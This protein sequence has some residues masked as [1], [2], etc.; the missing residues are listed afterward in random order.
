MAETRPPDTW[1]GDADHPP[2]PIEG[3]PTST[4]AMLGETERGAL[5]PRLV[6]SM[7]DFERW[8]GRQVRADR[9]VPSSVRGFFDNGGGRLYVARLVAASSTTASKTL[10]AFT[11]RAV[12]PGAWGTRVW[13][14]IR[15]A[16]TASPT[17]TDRFRMTLAYWDS[18]PDGFEP[19]DPFDPAQHGRTPRP[20]WLEDHDDLSVDPAS[21]DFFGTRLV[22]GKT[23]HPVSS[24]AILTCPMGATSPPPHSPVQGEFLDQGGEDGTSALEAADYIGLPSATRLEP[25]GLHALEN[26]EYRDVALVYAPYPLQESD[27]VARALIAHCESARFRFAVIDGPRD[28]EPWALEPRTALGASAYAACY[29]P[30]IHVPAPLDGALTVVPPGGHVLGVFARV[31]AERGVFKAPA[32]ERIRGAAGLRFTIDDRVQDDLGR[33]GVNAIRAFE[34][35]G[36]LVWGARTLSSDR[37]WT[38]VS[39]R[40]LLIYLERSIA[41]G[42]RWVVFEPNNERLWARVRD[43][44]R[45]F[46]R[47]QWRTGALAGHREQ[48]AF[49]V[50]C[51]RTTMSQDDILNGRLIAEIGVATMRP[52]EFVLFRLFQWTSEAA[53]P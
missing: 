50:N 8:F 7:A 18:R 34:G 31:D 15:A 20:Q 14:R 5:R 22:D 36:I 17:A 12:G 33:R 52:A 26:H 40:R 19:Y 4:A 46:L 35:R 38:Y 24:L 23:G 53:P 13:V 49:F 37:E 44:I 25:Q 10:G 11:L 30:W 1:P 47:A 43:S 39:T 9:F 51:D 42:T 45:L 28:V 16:S 3:V 27:A 29:A 21:P 6:T 48:D 2:P 41:E 32:N